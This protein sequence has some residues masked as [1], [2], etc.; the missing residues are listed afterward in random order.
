MGD[1]FSTIEE[2]AGIT[3]TSKD[4]LSNA[5]FCLKTASFDMVDKLQSTNHLI[6]V[7]TVQ[8]YMLGL[9]NSKA[10]S[11]HGDQAMIKL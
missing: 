3:Q 11:V 4:I 9:V 7:S 6:G 1:D 2:M 8:L 5:N 10:T